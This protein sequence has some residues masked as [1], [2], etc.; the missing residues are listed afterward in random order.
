MT[1]SREFIDHIESYV[2]DPAPLRLAADTASGRIDDF[3]KD[4]HGAGARPGAAPRG[5]ADGSEI[6]R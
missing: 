5:R 4:R 3:V 1:T 2:G 6:R